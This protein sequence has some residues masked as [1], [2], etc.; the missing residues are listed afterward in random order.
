MQQGKIEVPKTTIIYCHCAYYQIIPDGV[1]SAVLDALKNAGIEFEAVPD[2][3]R[4][5]ADKD[6]ALKSWAKADTIKII[7]CHPRAVRW[8]FHA[9]GAPLPQ[10]RKGSLTGEGVEFLNM[11]TDKTEKIISSLLNGQ[12][13]LAN[14]KFEIR[15]SKFPPSAGWIP[16]FPVID[17]DRCK[18]C[19]QCFNFCLFGVYELSE[20]QKVKVTKPANCKTNCPACARLCPQSAIIFPKYTDS[21]INGDKVEGT[22]P[23]V[24]SLNKLLG[25][26]I[27]DAIRQHSKAGK[28]FSKGTKQ[29]STE[30]EKY[31]VLKKLQQELDIPSDVLETLSPGQRG[32]A[33]VGRG[34]NEKE[35]NE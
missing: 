6:P 30:Q 8:L 16:W 3:C 5:C 22:S 13:N 12:P 20:E 11:R 29:Q 21:P 28:R 32:V 24:S 18:N 25:E 35:H 31:S 17:Y 7:A 4:M 10:S 9:A 34:T 27:Y 2:L 33:N 19:L 15:N 14:S 26:N 1:K 23:T